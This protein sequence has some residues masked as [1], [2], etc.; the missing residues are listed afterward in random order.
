[1]TLAIVL[2]IGRST[3]VSM[4]IGAT[5]TEGSGPWTHDPLG[6][7]LTGLLFSLI[8]L[9]VLGVT[10]LTSEYSSRSI[11]TTFMVNPGRTRVLAARTVIVGSLALF[12]GSVTVPGMF[13]MSQVMFS[14]YGL[15]TASLTDP[16]VARHIITYALAQAT[17]YTMVPF[18]IAWLMR[19]TATAITASFG[20]LFLPWM[21]AGVLPT[22]VQA[23]VIRY[24]PDVAV[25]SLAGYTDSGAPTYMTQGPAI[26]VIILWLVGLLTVAAVVL[27]RRDV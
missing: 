15:G 23:N 6:S 1:V 27:N 19:S 22:W 25:D 10:S 4:I 2:S 20:F 24:M 26:A 16:D 9:V 14:S 13:L 17:V 5:F 3:L 7:S 21:L 11:E 8:L 12:I 18:A